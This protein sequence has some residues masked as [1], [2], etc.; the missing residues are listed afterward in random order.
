MTCEFSFDAPETPGE[1]KVMVH[2]RST[3]CVG[4]DVRKKVTFKVLPAIFVKRPA[5]AAT[6]KEEEAREREPREEQPPPLEAEAP[7]PLIA[8]A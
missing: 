8:A 3:G 5:P 6:A 1:Y 2:C 4:V 7:P